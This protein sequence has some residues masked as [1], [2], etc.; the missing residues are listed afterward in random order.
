MKFGWLLTFGLSLVVAIRFESSSQ[1]EGKATAEDWTLDIGQLGRPLR[2]ALPGFE[3]LD[4]SAQDAATEITRVLRDD[5]AFASVYRIVETGV[6]PLDVSDYR[7]WKAT[8]TDVVITGRVTR[9][10]GRLLS[11]VR[12]LDVAAAKAAFTTEYHAPADEAR[13][14]AHRIADDML[15]HSGLIGVAQTRIAF[16]SRREGSGERTVW[17]MDYDGANQRQVTRGFLDLYPRWSPGRE[18]LLHLSFPKKD[19]PPRLVLLAEG[20]P[21]ETLFESTKMVFAGSWS[22]DGSRIAFS[23]SKD[24]NAEIYVMDRDG[25]RLRRLTDHPEIDVS[26]AWSPTG[27]EIGFTSS[28]TGSPQIY[29]MDDEGLNLRRISLEGSYNAEPAWSPSTDFSEIAYATRVEGGIFDVVVQ[30]LLTRRVLRITAGSGLSESPSWA[31]NGRHLVFSSTRTGES[32][33]FTA[34]RDGSNVRQLTFEGK[35]TTPGWGPLRPR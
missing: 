33:L 14:L 27:R 6:Y 22:P 25:S 12:F 18:S 26:P 30:D 15:A 35:N 31:P 19:I 9:L 2:I 11:E 28:R 21:A 7:S 5:I 23:S 8:G 17:L 34:N 16:T 24:G 20:R 1:S 4:G 3:F 10:E 29:I 13:D 32:Q